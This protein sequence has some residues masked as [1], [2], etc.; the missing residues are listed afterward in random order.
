MFHILRPINLL[1]L[2]AVQFTLWFRLS[3]PN[4]VEAKL[5]EFIL[6]CI[7]VI[8]TAAA[9]YIINDIVDIATDKINKPQKVYIKNYASK[10]KA[11]IAYFMLNAAAITAAIFVFDLFIII[12]TISSIAL[13]YL[14]S[15]KLKQTIFWGNLSIA[16]LSALP[17][18]EIYFYFSPINVNIDFFGYALFALLTT[19][20]REIVKDREDSEGDLK[21]GIKTLANSISVNKLKMVLYAVNG[22]LTICLVCFLFFMKDI[23]INIFLLYMVTMVLPALLIFVLIY[24]LKTQ[25]TYSRLSLFIKI[26]MFLGLIRLW[27]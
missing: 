27:F 4:V 20:L 12:V 3:V 15:S 8:C 14:Y 19:L 9:A 2:L 5:M 17:V 23:N 21:S 26:Y 7:S 16:L 11:F 25:Y 10:K 22:S 6:I 13:L 1:L 18:L 24:K